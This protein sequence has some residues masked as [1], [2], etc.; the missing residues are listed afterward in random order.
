[1]KEIR[2]LKS[3]GCALSK[4]KPI[5]GVNRGLEQYQTPSEI[6]SEIIW[7]AMLK[8]DVTDNIIYDLGSGNG[9]FGIGSLMIGALKCIFVEIDKDTTELLKINLN[10]INTMYDYLFELNKDYIILNQ[11]INNFKDPITSE[12]LNSYLEENK[13][14][15]D[16][17]GLNEHLGIE[18]V[19]KKVVLMNPPFGTKKA[20]A[21]RNFLVKSFEFADVIY[22]LH[23]QDTIGFLDAISR[24]NGFNITHKWNFN[25]GIKKSHEMHKKDNLKVPVVCVRMERK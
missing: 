10:E 7:S 24:D 16:E 5:K 9:V 18:Q 21:D 25:F 15:N 6:A 11:D 2:S 12:E 3:L 23:M 13:A 20:H 1:M 22:S 14:N 17:F 4:L 8:N 19:I